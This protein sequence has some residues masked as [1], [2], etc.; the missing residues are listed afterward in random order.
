[1]HI[2]PEII[3]SLIIFNRRGS[4]QKRSGI[5]FSKRVPDDLPAIHTTAKGLDNVNIRKALGYSIDR[6]ILA[7]T[8]LADGS[9]AAEGLVSFG[10]AGDGT[11][12]FRELNGN[13]SPFDPEKAKEYWRKVSKN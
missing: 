2:K 7:D 11:S 4:L 12:T 3:Q 8:I 10:V 1:M 6:S 9:A 13:L 5:S